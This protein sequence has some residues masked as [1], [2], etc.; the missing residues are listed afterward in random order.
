HLCTVEASHDWTGLQLK[1]AIQASS[2][3]EASTQRLVLGSGG[4]L[5]DQDLIGSALGN[6]EEADLLLIRKGRYDGSYEAQ[7]TWNGL[8]KFEIAGSTVYRGELSAPVLWDEANPRKCKFTHHVNGTA[9]WATRH[10]NGTH[11]AEQGLDETFEL[12]FL[13]DT[14]QA[15]F[16]GQFQRSYEGKLDLQIGRF[17]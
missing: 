5:R 7:P 1:E 4:E 6:A 12:E 14:P 10:T 9:E 16:R 2:E 15:G 11:T 3:V 17:C 13:A 8:C